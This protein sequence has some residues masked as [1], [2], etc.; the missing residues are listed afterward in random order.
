VVES[1]RYVLSTNPA[2]RERL[3][4]QGQQFIPWATALLDK[5]GIQRGWRAIDVG[6]G[7]LGILDLLAERVGPTGDVV[8]LEREPQLLEVARVVAGERGLT[9]VRLVEADAT[10]SGLPNDSFDFAHERLVLLAAA[11]PERIVAEMAA[12]VRPG[13]IVALEDYALS[14]R[15]SYPP[16]PAPERI[17]SV[18][19]ETYR[20]RGADPDVGFRLGR[21]LESAGLVDITV[22]AHV[23]AGYPA[24]LQMEAFLAPFVS[25]RD[26]AVSQGVV[27]SEEFDSLLDD[28]RAYLG[29]PEVLIMWPI[30]FQAWG[31]KPGR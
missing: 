20:R 26:E 7:P 24:S 23:R 27:T 8:G 15:L 3:L 11:D 12:F 21:L 1:R 22:D 16:S 6:C 10:A 13:G 5:L 17:G 14:T 28:L 19:R 9:N 30:F 31:R 29:E 18:F 25:L 2:E 4:R